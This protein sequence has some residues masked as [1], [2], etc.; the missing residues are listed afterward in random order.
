MDYDS[1]LDRLFVINISA[2]WMAICVSSL[3]CRF[4]RRL[5]IAP[6]L[7]RGIRIVSSSVIWYDHMRAICMYMRVY[8]A[9]CQDVSVYVSLQAL[10][11]SF[12]I[13]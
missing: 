4:E 1:S 8:V 12:I 2:I 6:D 10:S 13:H 7:S 11:S 5:Y 3:Y 9:V